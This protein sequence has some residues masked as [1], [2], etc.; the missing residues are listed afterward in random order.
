[1][2]VD[3]L[4]FLNDKLHYST[5]VVVTAVAS[6]GSASDA[7][8][9]PAFVQDTNWMEGWKGPDGTA[10]F[11]LAIDGLVNTWI[12]SS[13]T[14]TVYFV[15][16]YDARNSDQI[17]L[18]LKSDAADNPAGAF[19]EAPATYALLNTLPTVDVFT[20]TLPALRRYYRLQLLNS[21]RGGGTR[22]PK[23]MSL[24]VYLLGTDVFQVSSSWP[25]L[26]VGAGGLRMIAPSHDPPLLGGA[27]YNPST[28]DPTMELDVHFYPQPPAMWATMRDML[29][30]MAINNRNF[31]IRFTGA[32]SDAG[33][34]ELVMVRVSGDSWSTDRR[35]V[36][37]HDTKLSVTTA[38]RPL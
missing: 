33:M 29:N 22:L 32:K 14:G 27:V 6:S 8:Y 9:D 36:A 18:R 26:E 21:D 24:G 19:A 1:M 25:G 20:F 12:N 28:G 31:Y 37:V 10:D 15:I 35:S 11:Y 23:I 38:A 30:A 13:A 2:A 7:G 34:T 3:T 5:G 4:L 17:T 16:A